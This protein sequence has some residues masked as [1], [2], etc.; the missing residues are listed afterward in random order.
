MAFFFNESKKEAAK[1]KAK[2]VTKRSNA[3]VPIASLQKMGCAA[4]PRDKDD[5]LLSPK[6]E[7]SGKK[8]APVYLLGGNP[9][10]AED[11]DNMH[12]TDKAGQ[13][14]ASKFGG[15]FMKSEVRSNFITQCRGADTEVEIECCRNRIVAD[16]EAAQPLV[17]VTIGDAAMRWAVKFGT[18][19]KHSALN[20]RGALFVVKIGRHVCYLMPLLFPNFV[21]K[22]SFKKSE[23]EFTLEHDI[24]RIKALV[25][26]DDLPPAHVYEKPYD[27]GVELITGNEPGDMQRL[28][29]ALQDL[30]AE[31]DVG[32]DL[33]TNGLR[34]YFLKD[35]KIWMIAIGT[36]ERT[37]VFPLDH[38]E[39]WGTEGR[40][41]QVWSLVGEFLMN[42]GRKQ[43]HNLAMEME[44]LSYFF[45]PAILRKT[46]WEDT[47][48]MAHTL[49][50]QPG[51]KALGTQTVMH[52]GFD[53][54]AQSNIDVKRILEYPLRD[55]LRYCGMDTKWT[56][57]LART[58]MPLVRAENLAEYERK[59]RLA[60]TLILTEAKG[61]PVDF[62]Y[63]DDLRETTETTLKDI[64]G[65]LRRT[66]EIKEYSSRFGT[67]SPTAPAH[68]LKLLRDVCKRTEIVVE[69]RDGRRET[70][71]EEELSKIPAAEVP[72]VPLI[73]EHR[74]MS[75][76]LGTYILPLHNREIVCPD[77]R[78]RSKY[79]SMTAVTGRLAS[80]DPNVQNFPKR[81]HKE[82]RG[83]IYAPPGWWI[84]ALDY[85]QIEFRVV[86]MASGDP[87][88]VEA[89]WT[90]Y[91]VHKFWAER[92]VALYPGAKDWIVETFGVDWDE[93]GLKTLRQEAKNKWV[94]PQLFG[95]SAKSCAE[96][97][98]LPDDVTEDLVGEFWD[99]FKVARKWQEKLLAGYEKNLYV[100]CLGGRKR[101]GPMTKEQVI[102]APIQG[103]ALDIVAEGMNAVSERA[104]AEDDADLQPNLNVHDDL[105]FWI[106]DHCLTQK[107]DII[108]TEMCKPRFDYINV[109]LIVE[110][111]VGSRWHDLHEIKVYR[112]NE[113]FGTPNP[114]AKGKR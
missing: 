40:R 19:S 24:K 86:G 80:E 89:C 39:G 54:K 30:A 114:Y 103:T 97:L 44:W 29:L 63:V 36:F 79:S 27:A 71:G 11:E 77:G 113:L 93:K 7:P 100:E 4:C 1:P 85:G 28:Q 87:A 61:M 107:I 76:I 69:D 90:G 37:I 106:P 83:A 18:P 64:E 50:E 72:S 42:S 62:K 110:A 65:R 6:M 57:K 10:K 34:P 52:F 41:R 21:F 104:E 38:P 59:V 8:G 16:I 109:P 3:V 68:V 84:A 26:R 49:N 5:S 33:E 22:K 66:P 47:M 15:K 12:W 32:L 101:R 56:N 92:I 23:Y 108:A 45:G 13:M 112:S 94:F 48:A 81:K 67:F 74:A 58:L 82:V 53:V 2:A 35:P 43:A 96:S 51:T 60:S 73:L 98:H 31:P 20:H 9:S 102:N 55:T 70:T 46:E 14:I 111:S 75:K 88:I 95:A 78:V 99:T 105:S 91:D 17:I 25:Q